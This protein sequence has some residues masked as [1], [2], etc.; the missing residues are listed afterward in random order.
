[1]VDLRAATLSRAAESTG[2]AVLDF[3][4][5]CGRGFAAGV[6]VALTV[7]FLTVGFAVFFTREAPAALAGCCTGPERRVVTI[8]L[9]PD[10][11]TGA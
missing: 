7:F 1:M 9:I 5:L 4:D 10:V 11:G 3:A 8:D 6:T 2:F